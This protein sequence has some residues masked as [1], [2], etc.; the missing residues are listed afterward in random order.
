MKTSRCAVLCAILFALVCAFPQALS[1]DFEGRYNDAI[2][3]LNRGET[4]AA[5]DMFAG[6]GGYLE[7]GKY[8]MYCNA[9]L[10]AENGLYDLAAQ[11]LFTLD[12]FLDCSVRAVYYTA[13]DHEMKG[14]AP[15]AAELYQTIAAFQDSLDRLMN[16]SGALATP[17]PALPAPPVFAPTATPVAPGVRLGANYLEENREGALIGMVRVNDASATTTTHIREG[18]SVTYKSILN[19]HAGDMFRCV[20]LTLNGWYRILLKDG[21][22]AYVSYKYTTLDKTAHVKPDVPNPLPIMSVRATSE[23]ERSKNPDG[24]GNYYYYFAQNMLDGDLT[25]AW[26][27]GHTTMDAGNG[28]GEHADFEFR[29][30][31]QLEGIQ[32]LN[33]YQRIKEAFFQNSRPRQIE[34]SF[35]RGGRTDFDSPIVFELYDNLV[36]WQ[37]LTFAAETN[38][39]A[40]RIKVLDV[41]PGTKF[42]YDLGITEVRASGLE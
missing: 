34:V 21:R 8:A 17:E 5:A 27:P 39:T 1:E 15:K 33:G 31:V 19:G 29:T 23:R 28:I 7:A 10:M 20:G 37:Y 3:A 40:F 12:D 6:L 38:V 35:R 14:E 30:P 25:T 22:A 2:A 32:L 24:A 18:D 41:F 9:L 13:R 4:K 11:S 16:L 26:T 42:D 36:G